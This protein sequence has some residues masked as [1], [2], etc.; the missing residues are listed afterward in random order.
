M[1]I[2]VSGKFPKSKNVQ[3]F[4][5]NLMNTRDMVA[6]DNKRWDIIHPEIPDRSGVIPLIEKFD[7]GYFG[8]LLKC[9]RGK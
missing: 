8:K 1:L 4:K 9:K 3:E 5:D 6:S 7:P 2:G